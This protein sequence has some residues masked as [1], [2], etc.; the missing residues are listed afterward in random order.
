MHFKTSITL[1]SQKLAHRFAP[2]GTARH[3][4]HPLIYCVGLGSPEALL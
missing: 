1:E 3:F 4:Y 2:M